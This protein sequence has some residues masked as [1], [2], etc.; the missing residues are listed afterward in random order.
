MSE[1]EP[2]IEESNEHIESYLKS[3]IKEGL[4]EIA[5]ATTPSQVI[6]IARET[7]TWLDFAA[8][9]DKRLFDTWRLR[10]FQNPKGDIVVIQGREINVNPRKKIR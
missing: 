8:G 2:V 4:E 9:D 10:V 7:N 3:K 1:R 5:E 6:E